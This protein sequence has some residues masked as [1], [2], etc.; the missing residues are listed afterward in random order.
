MCVIAPEDWAG[1]LPER[2]KIAIANPPPRPQMD[3]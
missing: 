3:M 2:K 1:K